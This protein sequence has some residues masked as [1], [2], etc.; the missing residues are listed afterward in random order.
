MC[1]FSPDGKRLAIT[2][3]GKEAVRLYDT[4][5][6]QDVFTSEA[7]GTGFMGRWKYPRMVIPSLG[8]NQTTIYVWRAP[9]WEEINAAEAK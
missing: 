4:E 1:E 8:G 2:S 7:P 3:D 6:W 9:S 5:S